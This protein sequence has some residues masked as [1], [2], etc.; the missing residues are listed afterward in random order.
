MARSRGSAFVGALTVALVTS[1]VSA[2]AARAQDIDGAA[3]LSQ[4]NA[5]FRAG[6]FE[7]ALGFYS[8]ALTVA[9][10][11]SLIF[12]NIGASHYKLGQ[13][14]QAAQAFEAAADNPRLTAVSHYNLGLIA[15]REND[16]DAARRWFSLARDESMDSALSNRAAAALAELDGT[17]SEPVETAI[18]SFSTTLSARL[19]YDTNPFRSPSASYVDISLPT[20]PSIVPVEE[21]GFYIPLRFDVDY[22]RPFS[23]DRGL[24]GSYA[25]LNDKYIDSALSSADRTVHRLAFGGEIALGSGPGQ[26][27]LTALGVYRN[28]DETNFDPDDGLV[29]N[30]AGQSIGD[31]YDY[32]SIGLESELEGVIAGFTYDLRLRIE[33]R[34]YEDTFAVTQYDHDYA[35]IDGEMN[36]PVTGSAVISAR[37]MHY[38]RDY[39]DRRARDIQGNSSSANP[40]L[41]Y[42]YDEFRI[43]LNY[44]FSSGLRGQV[45]YTHTERS[46]QFVGYNDYSEDGIRLYLSQRFND[47][48]RAQ[49]SIEFT[50]RT[51]PRAF[52][53]D[54]PTAA[55]KAYDFVEIGAL[56]Q[57]EISDQLSLYGA[58]DSDNVDS[59][60]PRGAYDRV[61]TSV[62]VTW[63]CCQR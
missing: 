62:G 35:S 1:L 26:H 44:R 47:R 23:R 20:Q 25:L 9:D 41:E 49:F 42:V 31:R 46:D 54:E 48:L 40:T 3:A 17:V 63:L 52:A 61:R 55:A 50:D 56:L 45:R 39:A 11:T 4:G 57:Y 43:G 2:V 27:R 16:A 53:F 12:F 59:S 58:L 28:H 21:S 15:R 6:N 30:S 29:R 33:N 34:D 14:R 51:Y 8:N 36:F 60:D 37:Y 19:G 24:I 7:T 38:L 32:G 10:D 22:Y 5:E 18:G 13:Y